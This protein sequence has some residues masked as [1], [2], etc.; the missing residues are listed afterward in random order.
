MSE[1]QIPS[2]L[3]QKI[4]A[5]EDGADFE[6]QTEHSGS[7][8]M[9]H[10]PGPLSLLVGRDLPV[11]FNIE[12][13]QV[14]ESAPAIFKPDNGVEILNKGQHNASGGALSKCKFTV[15]AHVGNHST[16]LL[17]GETDLFQAAEIIIETPQPAPQEAPAP[18][19]APY[20]PVENTQPAPAPVP[21]Q[22][23]APA[24]Q[25]APALP[26][27]QPEEVAPEPVGEPPI[28]TTEVSPPAPGVTAPPANGT[29]ASELPAVELVTGSNTEAAAD[30]SAPFPPVEE[31]AAPVAPAEPVTMEQSANGSD[32]SNEP[33]GAINPG[34]E[35]G[36][37]PEGDSNLN[38][39]AGD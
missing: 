20:P 32:N 24:P 19:M 29:E 27:P 12:V 10:T 11:G 15:L 9:I 35:T 14:N 31:P 4:N 25:E 5:I 38:I 39:P 16:G 36:S 28:E 13:L 17:E 2:N 30:P 3:G 21:V 18:E 1:L 23:Q 7:L 33:A 37:D 26:Q 6:L 34:P 22:E 8:L